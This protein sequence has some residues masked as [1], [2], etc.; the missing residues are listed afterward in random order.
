MKCVICDERKPRRHCP[1]VGGD[2]CTICCGSEREQ[3]ISCPPGCEYLREARRHERRTGLDPDNLPNADLTVTE[4][5]L[6]EHR[7]LMMLLGAAIL[8]AAAGV[9]GAVDSDALEAIEAMIQSQRTLQSG[10]YYERR[11]DNLIARAMQEGVQRA[12]RNV[13]EEANARGAPPIRPAD[14]LQM[15][16]FYQRVALNSNNGRR[17]CRAFLDFLRGG[18]ALEPPPAEEPR[19]IVTP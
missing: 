18:L 13:E 3:T 2:I 6:D 12:L 14:N 9:E 17:K 19:L 1:G 16:V 7:D 11:P 4:N 8:T 5:F 10:L 15:L